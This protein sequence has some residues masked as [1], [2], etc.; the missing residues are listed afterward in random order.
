MKKDIELLIVD[1]HKLFRQSLRLMLQQK[2]KG[3]KITEATN[4]KALLEI[5]EKRKFKPDI[6]LMDLE[7]P[8]MDGVDT[9]HYLLNR[10]KFK[11]LKIIVLTMHDDERFVLKLLEEGIQGYILKDADA[12]EMIK[13]I[14]SVID[15]QYYVSQHTFDAIRR[16]IVTGS[17]FKSKMSPPSELLTT[18]EEEILLLICKEY[19]NKEMADALNLSVRTIDGHRNRVL[20]KTG[21][22]NTAGL[23][24]YALRTGFY[25]LD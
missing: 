23:V 14:K 2:L 7:M 5:L 19:T 21:M 22:K 15:G 12:E 3:I 16:D 10:K 13:A 24:K 20:K 4:G 25:S 17:R 11:D 9:I 1:D 8:V 6:I 18:R